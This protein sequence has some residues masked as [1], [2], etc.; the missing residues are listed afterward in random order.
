MQ[1]QNPENHLIYIMH[2]ENRPMLFHF[3]FLAPAKGEGGTQGIRRGVHT[4]GKS[5]VLRN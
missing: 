1:N 5:G 3:I 4:S 2:V